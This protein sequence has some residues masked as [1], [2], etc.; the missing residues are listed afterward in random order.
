LVGSNKII[1][2]KKRK[3]MNIGI[4]IFMILF[5]YLLIKVFI[6]F[7]NDKITI[8][9]VHEGETTPENNIIGLILRKEKVIDSDKAGYISYFQK[10]G[11]KI[12]K[13]SSVYAV[14]ETQQTIEAIT[15]NGE[16]VDL[17]KENYADIS[18]NF[19][20]FQKSFS[21]EN[22]ASVYE[23]KEDIQSIVLDLL[24]TAMLDHGK[25][26]KG[27]TDETSTYN[28]YKSNSSGI[29]TYYVDSFEKVKIDNLTKNMFKNK[30]YQRAS[31]RTRDMISK[32]KPV[33]KLVTSEEW[34]II[35]PLK[36]EQY[37]KLEGKDQ[38]SFT[39][40]KDDFKSTAGLNLFKNG[41]D[42]YAELSM[43]KYVYNYLHDRYLEINVEFETASGLK[44]PKTSVIEKNF[45]LVPLKY[46][47]NASD[48]KNKDSIIKKDYTKTG[49]VN[50]KTVDVNIFD[51]DDNYAYIDSDL[52]PVGTEIFCEKDK[53]SYKL[54]RMN[55]LTGAYCVNTGYA[56][57]R[58][59]EIIEEEKEY[60]IINKDTAYGLSAY[61][62][63]ILKAASAVDQEIIY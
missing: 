17:S 47:T 19:L 3:N 30:D 4:I 26:I 31:L 57:F 29:I 28:M 54:T 49:D 5:I 12:S 7:T 58:Q 25:A 16:T 52:L 1:K 59:I 9:E 50:Y 51:M 8:Y 56:V 43:N 62:H 22:F 20:S 10:E 11:A 36:A 23:F 41:K 27:K 48:S 34:S 60:Y 32:G 45:Y 18:Y 24:N 15:N 61:D 38:V 37:M 44:I 33:Y 42:Y 55:K 14:N 46:L 35:L 6:Y 53:D 63:I 13:K 40:L 39:I 21:N 2:F